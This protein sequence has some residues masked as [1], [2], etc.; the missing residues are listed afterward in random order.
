MFYFFI[1][2]FFADCQHLFVY[3]FF[4][5]SSCQYLFVYFF[6]WLRASLFFSPF[7]TS[8]YIFFL[9]LFTSLSIFFYCQYLLIYFFTYLFFPVFSV[10]LCLIFSFFLT[11]NASLF[12]LIFFFFLPLRA[13]LSNHIYFFPDCQGPLLVPVPPRPPSL[14]SWQSQV[15]LEIT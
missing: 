11:V 1:Q 14:P 12:N 2:L 5:F 7:S 15:H 13:S 8:L 10:P 3:S 9:T 6:S 4:F